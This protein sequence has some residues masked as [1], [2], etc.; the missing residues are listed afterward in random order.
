MERFWRRDLSEIP[1]L[2]GKRGKCLNPFGTYCRLSKR[3]R[4][5]V[6]MFS[7]AKAITTFL[8]SNFFC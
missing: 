4:G 7:P 6:L 5:E 3:S 1:Q 2:K 8:H